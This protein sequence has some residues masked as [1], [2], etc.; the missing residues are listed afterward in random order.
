MGCVRECMEGRYHQPAVDMTTP[1]TVSRLT[2]AHE[3]T[4][5]RP[6]IGLDNTCN[7]EMRYRRFD[8]P[9]R[10]E[11]Y[12]GIRFLMLKACL[13]MCLESTCR[14]KRPAIRLIP[15]RHIPSFSFEENDTH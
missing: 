5:R 4:D 15:R 6:P 1:L 14:F 8:L 10:E 9:H 12:N 3:E 13:I 11:G 7:K 2:A